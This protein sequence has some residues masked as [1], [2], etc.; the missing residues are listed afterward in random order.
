MAAFGLKAD[1]QKTPLSGV[2]LLSHFQRIVDFDA[3]DKQ[4]PELTPAPVGAKFFVRQ[5]QT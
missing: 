1:N 5:R 4:N 3:V 2:C